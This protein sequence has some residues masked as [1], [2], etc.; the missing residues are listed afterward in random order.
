MSLSCEK[1]VMDKYVQ[2]EYKIKK[3]KQEPEQFVQ[4][5]TCDV[6]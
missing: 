1:N 4:V 5:V 3:D 6:G 2:E